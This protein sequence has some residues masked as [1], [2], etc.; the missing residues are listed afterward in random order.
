MAFHKSSVDKPRNKKK[1]LTARN[2]EDM[3]SAGTT[4]IIHAADLVITDAARE[5]AIDLNIK[6]INPALVKARMQNFTEQKLVTN[7][8][9]FSELQSLEKRIDQLRKSTSLN[10]ALKVDLDSNIDQ[11]AILSL[12]KKDQTVIFELVDLIRSHWQPRFK[13]NKQLK[14]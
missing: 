14:I 4:E 5:V 2:V 1:F 9:S 6:I 11:K 8:A 3:A 12:N 10:Q 7:E 13:S